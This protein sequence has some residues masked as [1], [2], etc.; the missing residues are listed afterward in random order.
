VGWRS[1]RR[2]AEEVSA[3]TRVGGEA[4]GGDTQDG[5]GAR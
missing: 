2:G 5:G 3:G 4:E 1:H